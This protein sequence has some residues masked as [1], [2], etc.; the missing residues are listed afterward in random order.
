M[1]E[2]STTLP[3]PA[4]I[5]VSTQPTVHAPAEEA[6]DTPE[7]MAGPSRLARLLQQRPQW[8][9]KRLVRQF[10]SWMVSMLVHMVL[11]L[12]IT[13]WVVTGA[14]E[15]KHVLVPDSFDVVE[16]NPDDYTVVL[17]EQ[18]TASTNF[19]V[20]STGA[21][22][23]TTGFVGGGA[24]GGAGG[25]GALA[26]VSAPTFDAG[27]AAAGIGKGVG[28]G[29]GDVGFATVP[30][31]ALGMDVPEG[32]PG[33]AQAVVDTYQ[34]AMDRITQEILVMLLK[35]K[36]LVVWCFD[37]SESMKDD[38]KEI[39][40]RVE[41]VY[42]ELGLSGGTKGDALLTAVCSF[43]EK[44]TLHTK[45]P[46][47]DPDE[48]RN[49]IAS[50]KT[51]PTGKEML[52]QSV[53]ESV[54]HFRSM[55]KQGQRQMAL[56]LVTDESGDPKTNVS[57]LEAAISEA[58][59]TRC[60][61]YVLGREAVFGYPYAQMRWVHPIT[62]RTHWLPID[63]GPESAGV[64]QL[65]TNGFY[66]RLDAH[67]S[68][69]GPYEQA[70]MA[71]ETGGV[72][73]MLPSPE[74]NLVGRD[75]RKYALEA[76]RP[77]MPD[78]G[79]RDGYLR[80]R[81]ASPLRRDVYA[82]I[83]KLNPYNPAAAPH[84]I[85]RHTFSIKQDEF[86][87]QVRAEQ[88]KAK[89]YIMYLYDREKELD[90]LQRQRDKETYPRWQA[91]YD[92]IHAQVIAYKVRMYEYGAYLDDFVKHPKPIKNPLGVNR[93]TNYWGLAWRQKTLTDKL[94]ATDKTRSKELFAKVI[95]LHPGTPWSARAE[96]ELK[97]GFGVEL[98]EGY[99]PPNINTGTSIP[100]P[101]L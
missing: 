48:I 99:D 90:A 37:E 72:F 57:V 82:I 56:I 52:C 79:P 65:Q 43:G 19:A 93:A 88:D 51:D 58:K 91:N 8:L 15:Q 92:L 29:I 89:N 46:T 55:A 62:Q 7:E 39:L 45:K 25:Q 50:I 1:S 21:V 44:W 80:E 35:S 31:R 61:I 20:S 42:Q 12:V 98:N 11:F 10:G 33:D 77:Y 68:G 69:F 23:S 32:S 40:Q 96:D 4:S 59:Q 17:D 26:S 70:R 64:E 34:E 73:F 41:R 47:Y 49:A 3:A 60:R 81:D 53:G 94:T 24:G 27:V 78:M 22:G 75:N 83:E 71:R 16:H 9:T 86:V 76:I 74:V 63:R 5:P 84:I 54:S 14:A 95:S 38:Q 100:I 85:M 28:I 13:T 6:G 67:A 87:K 18:T 2:S 97:R 66:R 101:K 36:V 30:R